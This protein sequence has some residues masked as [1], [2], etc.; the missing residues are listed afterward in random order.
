[1][2]FNN[3]WFWGVFLSVWSHLSV[4]ETAKIADM[5]KKFN[6]GD[7]SMLLLLGLAIVTLLF[8]ISSI[9]TKIF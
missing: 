3:N 8:V 9:Y 5:P 6:T 4:W 2:A 7:F 1:M